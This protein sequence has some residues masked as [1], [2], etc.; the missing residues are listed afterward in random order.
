MKLQ[1]WKPIGFTFFAVLSENMLGLFSTFLFVVM[2]EHLFAALLLWIVGVTFDRLLNRLSWYARIDNQTLCKAI[3]KATPMAA[4]S[5]QFVERLAPFRH[6][7][8]LALALVYCATALSTQFTVP[9]SVHVF[10]LWG[11]AL[12][13]TV[14]V[15]C[16]PSNRDLA[17]DSENTLRPE[18]FKL[19]VWADNGNFMTSGLISVPRVTLL[20]VSLSG[21][22]MFFICTVIAT[23]LSLGHPQAIIAPFIFQIALLFAVFLRVFLF[24]YRA[25]A[26]ARHLMK[27]GVTSDAS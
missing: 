23:Q 13:N 16:A 11:L 18:S 25:R 15:M 27:S 12:C 21:L 1:G 8:L 6:K 10:A 20:I 19:E 7:L 3:C 5:N 22:F 17:A 26:I 2:R 4:Q 9:N 24:H 14:L